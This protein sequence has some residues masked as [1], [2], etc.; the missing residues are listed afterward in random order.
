MEGVAQVRSTAPHLPSHSMMHARD[1]ALPRSL[2]LLNVRYDVTPM[3]Y[4]SMAITE[5]G[6][7]P[8]TSVPV[9]IREYHASECAA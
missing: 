3:K 4:I 7:L 6:M 1:H 5:V 8:P 2:K 9:V